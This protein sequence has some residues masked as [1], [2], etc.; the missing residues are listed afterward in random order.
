MNNVNKR[1]M[2]VQLIFFMPP[3]IILTFSHQQHHVICQ[4]IESFNQF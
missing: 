4:Q 1:M 3:S 2:N